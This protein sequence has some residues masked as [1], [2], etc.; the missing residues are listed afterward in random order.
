MRLPLLAAALLV[1]TAGALPARAQTPTPGEVVVNE[2][3]YDPPSGQ[4]S[5]NEWVE[6]FNR[7]SRTVDLQ[8]LV[9]SDGPNAADP[10]AESV[11]LA[12]GG[13]V[14]LVRNAADFD[15]A[16]PG[17]VRIAIT[18]FPALNN[19]GDTPQLLDGATVL[20]AVPYQPSW[21]GA[22]ASLERI[23][24][25]GPSDDASNFGTTLD[26]AGG[27]PGAEN[28]LTGG[29]GDTTPPDLTGASAQDETTIVAV[30]DEALDAASAETAANYS[31]DGGINTPTAAVFDGDR[32]VTLTLATALTPGVTYT[33]TAT[34]IEDLAGNVLASDSE[35][36]VLSGDGAPTLEVVINEFLYD[37]P[38]GQDA[39]EYVE[40]FN[41]TASEIDLGLYT[42]NDSTGDDQPIADGPAPIAANGYAV[43]VQDGTKFAAVFPGVPFI[44]QPSW[45][46][47]NNTG[48]DIVLRRLDG[49]LVDR[50]SYTPSEWGGVDIAVERISV[51][52][53]SDTPSNWAEADGVLGTPGALNTAAG[54][55]GDTTPP[56]LVSALAV[57]ATTVLVEF[58][59]PVTLASAEDVGNYLILEGSI[60]PTAASLIPAAEV[61]LTLPTPL[62]AGQTYTLQTM[63]LED[64]AGNVSGTQT[65]TF[66]FVQADVPEPGDLVLNEFLYDPPSGQPSGEYV[67]LFN[68]SART[69]DLSGFT[70]NDATGDDTVISDVPVQIG[71]G[72]YAVVVQD[73]A[74]FAAVFPGVPFVEQPTWSALN[75]SGDDIV[76]K[77]VDG[78]A[79]NL[80]IDFL[81]YTP[82]AWGG[83]DVAVER[84][85]PD[86][87]SN[88]PSNWAEADGVLGT[89]GAMNTA[90][91]VDTTPPSLVSAEAASATTVELTFSETV[92]PETA[93]TAANYTLPTGPAVTAAERLADGTTVRLTL[94]A[95]LASPQTYEVTAAGI[96]D[97]AG[98]VSGTLSATFF[99]G[100]GD[101]PAPG[102]LVINEFLYDPPPANDSGEFV[103]LLN[104][105][106][107]TLDL[108]DFTLN[109]SS[110][111]DEPVTSEPA[112][113]GP[114][115]YAVIVQNAD[116]FA[117]AYPG[118]A[119]V[120]QPAW[121]ALNNSGDAI[122]LKADGVRIDSLFYTPEWGGQDASVE[123][124]D[125]DGPSTS[126]ANFATTTDP[127]GGTPGEQN[128]QFGQD[129]SGP[130]LVSATVDRAGRV[131]TVR[132]SEPLDP[133][134]VSVAA[135]TVD[136][137]APQSVDYT[138]Q[139]STV[140][141]TL[142]DPLATGTVTITAT[143]LA[144]ELGNVTPTAS[145]QVDFEADTTPPALASAFISTETTVDVRFTEPV[146]VASA[147]SVGTYLVEG[148]GMPTGVSIV[149]G[150][151]GALGAT[152][153][154]EAAFESRRL[155]TLSVS[156]LVDL[157]GNVR[158]VDTAP[159]FFGDADTPAA[160]EL[161]INEILYDPRDG[162]AGEYVELL[163]TTADR[164]FDLARLSLDDGEADD[165]PVTDGTFPIPPGAFVAVVRD[166]ETFSAAF[167]DAP[168]V[169]ADNFQSLS[170]AGAPLVLRDLTTGAVADSV[171]YDPDWHRVELDDATGVS[172]ERRDPFGP[173]NAETNWTSSLDLLGGTPGRANSVRTAEGET[174]A[175]PGLDITSPFAPDEGESARIS[176]VLSTDAALVRARIFDGGGR[177]VREIEDGRLTAREGSL[178]WDGR[179]ADGERLRVGIYVVLVEAVDVE[180]GTSEAFRS[181]VVI[182][183][184]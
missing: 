44:E 128:T 109:D 12:P 16:Y 96:A 103:E 153:S 107:K 122:V 130:T 52:G 10:I 65:Q 57:D 98:N 25:D 8:G 70:L 6:V 140:T 154:F 146:T 90:F 27:T 83:S 77:F 5:G 79:D 39:G 135:F 173:S 20:D 43:V 97:L 32:T 120:E 2:I 66:T 164:V 117:A 24:P 18:G 84:K 31:V 144:D 150:D 99:F 47:L 131:V 126:Q 116:L 174:P 88:D 129:T 60:Q 3:M 121:S 175:A 46:A 15:A 41:Q 22:D 17:V 160:G 94:A 26:A 132:V 33:L 91:E 80:T 147:E 158:D 162:S 183:R 179:D 157:A 40:L 75:N 169:V 74:Q 149:F 136:G 13:Y 42:L 9:F 108:R 92:D 115:E 29:G 141:L 172:L 177:L 82:A 100:E 67:E 145:V 64:L 38:P 28:S 48:D 89:P 113:V 37:P 181:V 69:F 50:L 111:D 61:Q 118:V 93:E 180:G 142:A 133:A 166:G 176:Y 170:N 45:S 14:V 102:D 112:F 56:D 119:F 137:A 171:A 49:T 123:R 127:R 134:T 73:G 143:D 58:S 104:R 138:P 78:S 81:S 85:D 19:S 4:P 30:F 139:T 54:G 87:P 59:E 71:P 36:F 110:G 1:L 72:E 151:G 161:V 148:V 156:G 163:N 152:L 165:D 95:P 167:P 106:D 34:D 53:P 76:L 35:T 168:F 184:R 155:Y 182:G 114:G 159:L 68:R 124:R 7:S 21:G 23:D 125:P 101:A 86:G 178:A 51:D 63:G 11:P 62:V 105:S 55:T